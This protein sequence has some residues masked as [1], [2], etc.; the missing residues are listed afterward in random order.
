MKKVQVI[1]L[2]MVMILS[3][4]VIP[5]LADSGPETIE[6]NGFAG[7]RL[8]IC[9]QT[10]TPGPASSLPAGDPAQAGADSERRDPWAARQGPAQDR[11]ARGTSGAPRARTPF[12]PARW[13]RRSVALSH[14]RVMRP[15]P[16]SR[17]INPRTPAYI[18]LIYV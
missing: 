12:K 11:S 9:D 13:R 17:R 18:I 3:C 10:S 2:A 7:E 15:L 5:A 8:L 1:V 14:A 16:G 6:A 4:A